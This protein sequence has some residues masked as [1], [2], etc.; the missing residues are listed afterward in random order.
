M[1]KTVEFEIG[2]V[3]LLYNNIVV[4]QGFNAESAIEKLY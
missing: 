1:L 4:Q 2:N 3:R